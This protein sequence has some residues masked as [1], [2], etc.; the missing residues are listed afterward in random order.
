MQWPCK[1]LYSYSLSLSLSFFF[2]FFKRYGGLF[3]PLWCWL[4]KTSLGQFL[5]RVKIWP[6]CLR[7]GYNWFSEVRGRIMDSNCFLYL[8]L[9]LYL[10]SLILA[11]WRTLC[12]QVLSTLTRGAYCHLSLAFL[13]TGA[14][15]GFLNKSVL[16]LCV[17]PVKVFYGY[18]LFFFSPPIFVC[19]NLKLCFHSCKI[20]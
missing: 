16:S 19:T 10:T 13:P 4:S 1:L 3:L 20:I 6:P 12:L 7:M 8:Y 18:Y 17:I 11:H 15:V 2:F 5:Q 9:Y 14:L